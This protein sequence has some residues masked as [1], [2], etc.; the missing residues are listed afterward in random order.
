M[1]IFKIINSKKEEL[2]LVLY[3]NHNGYYGHGFE[4]GVGE[5]IIESD[6]L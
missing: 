2:F 6:I 1:A 5:N 4:F 3:N